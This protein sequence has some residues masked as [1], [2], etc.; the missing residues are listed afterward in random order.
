MRN[1]CITLIAVAIINGV[2]GM[3]SPE[4]DIKKYIR[5]VGSI[6]L[7]LAIVLPLYTVIVDGGIDLDPLFSPDRSEDEKYEDIYEGALSEGGRVEAQRV[8]KNSISGELNMDPEDFDVFVEIDGSSGSIKISSVSVLLH[9][10]A[11]FVDHREISAFI[12]ESLDCPCSVIY[13]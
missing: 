7:L 6:G 11:I 12:N 1:F 10:S 8:I 4:G 9:T 13:D 2:L 5:L 3:I